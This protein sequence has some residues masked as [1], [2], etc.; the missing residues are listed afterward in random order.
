MK[1]L[2]TR[3][4]MLSSGHYWLQNPCQSNCIWMTTDI[5][6]GHSETLTETPCSPERALFSLLSWTTARWAPHSRRHTAPFMYLPRSPPEPPTQHPSPITPSNL[7][8]VPTAAFRRKQPVVMVTEETFNLHLS[9]KSL[10]S[11]HCIAADFPGNKKTTTE[12]K[13]A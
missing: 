8:P 11:T 3:T 4:K 7:W 10:H 12:V 9:W 13:Q 5:W 2:D 1:I 6:E